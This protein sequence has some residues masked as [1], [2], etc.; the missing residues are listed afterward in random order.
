MTSFDLFLNLNFHN[1]A[2]L[3]LFFYQF[4]W[5]KANTKPL[6]DDRNHKIC[7]G[8]FDVRLEDQAVRG[9]KLLIKSVSHG[10]FCQ[11][12]KRILLHLRERNLFSFQIRVVVSA[13]Q[14]ILAFF[15]QCDPKKRILADRSRYD[16]Q[17]RLSGF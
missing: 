17:I 15:D 6:T 3:Q 16:G 7:R 9:I 13:G 11:R 12:D 2:S 1:A 10:I 5:D 14:D 4:P 8:K